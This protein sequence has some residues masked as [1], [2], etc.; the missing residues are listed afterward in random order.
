MAERV[1]RQG[2]EQYGDMGDGAMVPDAGEPADTWLLDRN[3]RE[4]A[5]Y[6]FDG[7]ASVVVFLEYL[8]SI[9]D[10]VADAV[11]DAP[12]VVASFLLGE[13]RMTGGAQEQIGFVSPV[14]ERA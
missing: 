5:E 7:R 14:I 11:G 10:L 6:A 4:P 3:G 9:W 13:L 1:R 8:G 2:D 12:Q